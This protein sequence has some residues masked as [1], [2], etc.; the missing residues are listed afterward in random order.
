MENR[1]GHTDK[2]IIWTLDWNRMDRLFMDCDIRGGVVAYF[3][4]DG[5]YGGDRLEYY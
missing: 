4:H 2:Y 5:Y 3:E 1:D